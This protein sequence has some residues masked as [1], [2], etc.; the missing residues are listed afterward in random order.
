M[1]TPSL[2]VEQEWPH[3]AGQDLG[4]LRGN[5]LRHHLGKLHFHGVRLDEGAQTEQ[6]DLLHYLPGRETL[7]FAFFTSA[8][9]VHTLTRLGA[10]IVHG[11]HQFREVVEA[12]RAGHHAL[13]LQVDRLGQLTNVA[14]PH[15]LEC[16]L[17]FES[18]KRH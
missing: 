9:A 13:L 14:L 2:V 10:Y 3:H 1:L 12:L 8:E 16:R 15:L 6:V 7:M 4:K 18:L 5:D 17:T 11:V